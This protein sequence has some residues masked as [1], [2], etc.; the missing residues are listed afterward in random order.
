MVK[1][2]FMRKPA[3]IVFFVSAL[4]AFLSGCA[5]PGPDSDQQ[6]LEQDRQREAEREQATFRAGLPPVTNPGPTR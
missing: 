4:V 2:P 6:A 1:L 5:T 3:V